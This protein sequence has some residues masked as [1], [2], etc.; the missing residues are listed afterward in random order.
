MQLLGVA[1]EMGAPGTAEMAAPGTGAAAAAQP[2]TAV[3]AAEPGADGRPAMTVSVVVC[4]YA[5]DRWQDIRRAVASLRRQTVCPLEVLLVVDHNRRLAERLRDAE[6]GVLVVESDH[7]RGLSGARNA[8]LAAARGDVVAFLDDDAEAREDW[9]AVLLPHYE[10]DDVLG[11]GGV[12]L[13]VWPQERPGWFPPEYEWVVGCSYEGLPRAVAAVRN[14]LGAN[15][16]FRRRVFESVGGFRYGIGRVGTRP[17]GCEETEFCIRAL[18]SGPG[19]RILHE[20]AAVVRHHVHPTRTRWRYLRDRCY[21][22]GLSK[23]LVARSVGADAAL[24]TERGYVTHTLPAGI[25]R[26]IRRAVRGRDGAAAARA[27]TAVAGVCLASAGYVRGR[28][29]RNPLVESAT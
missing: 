16:S 24:E 5:E 22:E 27:A 19:G 14:L 2:E 28:L 12:A 11:V 9:L 21:A 17:V 23:A 13:A 26:D 29:A 8:G 7:P 25:G 20:P 10:A 1:A 6:P 3:P 18:K 15:M 4:A